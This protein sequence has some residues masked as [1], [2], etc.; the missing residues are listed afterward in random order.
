MAQRSPRRAQVAPLRVEARAL[1][2]AADPPCDVEM[3][4]TAENPRVLVRVRGEIETRGDICSLH[5]GVNDW[6]QK[7]DLWAAGIE[8]WSTNRFVFDVPGIC[9]LNTMTY[10]ERDVATPRSNRNVTE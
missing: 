1:I 4:M 6:A 10:E 2:P 7:G 8:L 5:S 9:S 3:N